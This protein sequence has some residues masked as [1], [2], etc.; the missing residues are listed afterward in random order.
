MLDAF[1]DAAGKGKQ[2]MP[3]PIKERVT[4]LQDGYFTDKFP[5]VFEKEAY[6]DPISNRR[7]ERLVEKKK[8]V[9]TKPFITF[10]GE[11]KP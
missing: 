7:K 4:G 11:K 2:M 3:G 9:T 6:T 5:R 1:N 8:N 10:S